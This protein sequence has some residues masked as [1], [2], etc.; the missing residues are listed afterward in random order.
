[1]VA[2]LPPHFLDLVYDAVLKSFWYK[3]SLRKFLRRTGIPESLLGDLPEEESKREWLDRIFPKLE[4]SES[5]QTIIQQMAQFLA[6]QKSFPD[7][8]RHEDSAEMTRQAK[9]A[10]AALGKYLAEKQAEQQDEKEKQRVRKA[11]EEVRKKNIRS[12]TDL[13]KLRGRLDKELCPQLGKQGGG[14]AFQEWFYDF[15]AFSDIDH[16]CPYVTDGRQID[17]SVT[18]DGTT[19]LVELKF[20][21]EQSGATDIDSLL[22]KVNSKADNTM[23]I[24]VSMSGYSSVAIK[25]ASSAKTPLLL[26]D[27]SH[28][29]M[30]LGGT[31]TFANIVRR[32]RRH[33]SQ[34]GCAFLPTQEF[35]GRR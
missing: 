21:S 4:E 12:Q 15:M 30:A 9:E 33:S 19:Y 27:Y 22:G 5:G 6:D 8:A 29:Y 35:G 17:G 18:I 11:A 23:G 32:V 26:F 3:N 13:T 1:M 2:R 14:Y 20:T 16:R 10:V 7:L 24:M 25:Q 31:E 28:L 34:T